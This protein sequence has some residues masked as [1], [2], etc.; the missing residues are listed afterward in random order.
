MYH[1]ILCFALGSTQATAFGS[2]VFSYH[3]FPCF[4]LC[5]NMLNRNEALLV[6]GIPDGPSLFY[7]KARSLPIATTF[8]LAS[9]CLH[10][11]L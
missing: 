1:N 2:F 6:V 8:L 9:D 10:I 5:T 7:A 11:T 4:L 3:K